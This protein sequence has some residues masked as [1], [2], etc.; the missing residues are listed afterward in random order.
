MIDN[1]IMNGT[2]IAN[3]RIL[4]YGVPMIYILAFSVVATLIVAI[5]DV[6]TAEEKPNESRV[7]HH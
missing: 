3:L 5:L 7:E 2:L 6:V 4:T 1:V